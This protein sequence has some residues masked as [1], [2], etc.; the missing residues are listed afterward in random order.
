[1]ASNLRVGQIVRGGKGIYTITRK[2]RDQVGTC[3]TK[4]HLTSLSPKHTRNCA[5]HDNVVLKCASQRRLQREKQVSQKFR[6]HA[7]I[8]QLIDYAEDPHCLVL[9]HLQEDALRS[10]SKAPISRGNIKIIARSILFALESLHANGLV[11]TGDK[12]FT[13]D[14]MNGALADLHCKQDIKPDNIL[15][16]YDQEST[17][18]LLADCGDAYEAN[19][20]THPHGA[21]HAIGAAIFRSPEALLGL[22]WSTSTDVWS[23]GATVCPPACVVYLTLSLVKL[24]SLFWGR[25][26]HIFK[27]VDGLSADDPEFAAHVLMEQARYFGPFP[28]RYN[29]LLDKESESILAAIHILIEQQRTR[30]PF[31]LVE[32]EEVLPEDKEF[33]CDVMKL[34]PLERPTARELLQHRWFDVL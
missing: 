17:T 28:L 22:H 4:G 20:T 19:L 3:Y 12:S 26:F 14:L 30:K 29:E 15:L 18:V 5:T 34:D 7:C 8:R 25:G 24:M 16:N 31:S 23:F 27:P 1:M 11:H 2:L 33:L 21:A 6:G 32:D 10:A 13:L 9:E